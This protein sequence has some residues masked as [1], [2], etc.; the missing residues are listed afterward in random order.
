[1]DAFPLLGFHCAA[2]G[3]AAAADA[4]GAGMGSGEWAPQLKRALAAAQR[5]S[6]AAQGAAPCQ[7]LAGAVAAALAAVRRAVLGKQAA[8]VA[9]VWGQST[10]RLAHELPPC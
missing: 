5:M 4:G 1:M 3:R 10:W 7:E 6:S 8:I 2:L 9:G